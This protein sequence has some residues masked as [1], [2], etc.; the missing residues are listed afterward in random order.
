MY[1]TDENGVKYTEE[2]YRIYTVEE[3]NIGKGNENKHTCILI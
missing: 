1:K 3:L 2:G